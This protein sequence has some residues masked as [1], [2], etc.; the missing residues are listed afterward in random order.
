MMF[1]HHS[2]LDAETFTTHTFPGNLSAMEHI[3][4]II[5]LT[6]LARRTVDPSPVVDRDQFLSSRECPKYAPVTG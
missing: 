1:R 3:I 4:H 6:M 2:A 5:L